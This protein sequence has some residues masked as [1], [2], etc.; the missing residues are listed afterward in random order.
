M[1]LSL[2]DLKERVEKAAWGEVGPYREVY[3]AGLRSYRF[4]LET[5][6]P[7]L[8]YMEFS[9][10]HLEVISD[11]DDIN[12]KRGDFASGQ[13]YVVR[14]A[15]RNFGKTTMV[16][17]CWP[18]QRTCYGEIEHFVPFS[19]NEAQAIKMGMSVRDEL[20]FNQRIVTFFGDFTTDKWAETEWLAKRVGQDGVVCNPRGFNQKFRGM[21]HRSKRP[22][23]QL[24]DDIEDD[25]HIQSETQRA[26]Y[27]DKF[28]RA[29]MKS[30][31]FMGEGDK[32]T[33]FTIFVTGTILHEAGLLQTLIDDRRFNA[34]VYSACDDKLE[35]LMPTFIST[36]RVKEEWAYAEEH[37]QLDIFNSEMRN[38]AISDAT[39]I[40]P[41]TFEQYE[42]EEIQQPH[43]RKAVMVDPAKETTKESC[44][45]A[46]IAVALDVVARKI[47]FT[48]L[49][50]ERLKPDEA[51]D[52]AMDMIFRT[53][54]GALAVELIGSGWHIRQ[55]YQN[56]LKELGLSWIEWIELKPGNQDKISRIR[57]ALQPYYKEGKVKHN[58]AKTQPLEAQLTS[59]PKS[60]YLDAADCASYADF[61][62]DNGGLYFQAP[63]MS[64]EEFESHLEE[65]YRIK[66]W[67][68]RTEEE[69][70]SAYAN[71]RWAIV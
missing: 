69:Q 29:I 64:E 60:K 59:F 5:F 68:R 31:Q 16:D 71:E 48:D 2:D 20:Q 49:I 26:K 7:D 46:I 21:I 51:I 41:K 65:Q 67:S 19:A 30:V 36:E 22:D 32:K 53:G 39:R 27:E 55:P 47:F 12:L 14:A 44:Y 43:I 38:L 11:I 9:P 57:H 45:T 25:E 17:K 70:E 28:Y 58:K 40:F 37:N 62:F 15:P 6:F 8:F 18:V 42:P 3:V 24:G 35:S 33:D 10:M 4:F 23:F 1:T 56:K 13:N 52:A 61:L 66:N 34:K 54:A 50:M 63:E